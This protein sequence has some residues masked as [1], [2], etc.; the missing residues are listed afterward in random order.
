MSS[1]IPRRLREGGWANSGVT[2][3]SYDPNATRFRVAAT[4]PGHQNRPVL[5]GSR[6]PNVYIDTSAYKAS[7]YPHELVEYLRGHGRRK[8]LF[9]SNHP[10]WH[11][12]DCL[13]DLAGL[14]LDDETTGLFLH[15]NAQRVFGR[16]RLTRA[17]LGG[18]PQ[19]RL[20]TLGRCFRPDICWR[21]LSCPSP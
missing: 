7:R 4:F 16:P 15:G 11:A 17:L 6:F 5:G 21:S 9:G 12:A 3:L 1:V 18:S 13:R 2:H 20:D 10:A 19:G 8:V 14:E